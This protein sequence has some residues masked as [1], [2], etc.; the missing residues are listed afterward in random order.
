MK[1]A[2]NTWTNLSID[3]STDMRRFQVS[4]VLSCCPSSSII[5]VQRKG[6]AAADTKQSNFVALLVMRD[7]CD[8][9]LVFFL[10]H[11]SSCWATRSS[12]M[13]GCCLMFDVLCSLNRFRRSAA[14]DH[15]PVGER[16]SCQSTKTIKRSTS[17]LPPQ[18]DHDGLYWNQM[19]RSGNN[20]TKTIMN[21][22]KS[23]DGPRPSVTKRTTTGQTQSNGRLVQNNFCL[24]GLYLVSSFGHGS[25]KPS[26]RPASIQRV[27]LKRTASRLRFE[28]TNPCFKPS[29]LT[30]LRRI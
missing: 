11:L 3:E 19:E 21:R 7:S 22:I 20:T 15:R 25:I 27:W 2:D 24:S 30:E 26:Y 13:D 12:R 1:P 10:I 29:K 9:L 18:N 14:A 17:I 5:K 6:T 16:V 23:S 28:N 8:T 4:N